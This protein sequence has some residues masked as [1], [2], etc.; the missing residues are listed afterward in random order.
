MRPTESLFAR[1]VGLAQEEQR[2]L[3]DRECRSDSRQRRALERLLELAREHPQDGE[4]PA[5][6]VWSARD[7]C[8]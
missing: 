2:L 5:L 3:L 4:P 1:A 7:L 6:G 8:G